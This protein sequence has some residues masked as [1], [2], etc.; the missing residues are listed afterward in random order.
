MQHSR[1]EGHGP[2][3]A[4][5]SDTLGLP[6][7]V[8]TCVWL[9]AL[10]IPGAAFAPVPV[11]RTLTPPPSRLAAVSELSDFLLSS[12]LPV[13]MDVSGLPGWVQG[14]L[15]AS[16]VDV[17]TQPEGARLLF[18][19][20]LALVFLGAYVSTQRIGTNSWEARE[21]ARS[22]QIR[23]ERRKRSGLGRPPT[24]QDVQFDDGWL[25]DNE[26]ERVGESG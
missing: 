3:L 7:P 6:R 21:Q 12:A 13:K 24:L 9:A 20:Q 5:S 1:R 10:A 22:D 18:G 2:R 16:G 25:D 4:A 19:Q 15:Q 8:L 17:L 23:A 11:P 26:G 14:G